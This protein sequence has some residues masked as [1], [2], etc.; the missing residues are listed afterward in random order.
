M[1]LHLARITPPR[2]SAHAPLRRS[3]PAGRPSRSAET[4]LLALGGVVIFLDIELTLAYL[5]HFA[6][7]L[8]G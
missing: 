4:A 5:L 1:K 2:P 3:L 6:A 8:L 7:R